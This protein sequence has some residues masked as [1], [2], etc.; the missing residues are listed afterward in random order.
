MEHDS[1]FEKQ[2][3][4]KNTTYEENQYGV[5]HMTTRRCRSATMPRIC[6]GSGAGSAIGLQSRAQPSSHHIVT[7]SFRYCEAL[8]A[9]HSC[10]LDESAKCF[11]LELESSRI[12]TIQSGFYSQIGNLLTGSLAL[13][14]GIA[15]QAQLM[16]SKRISGPSKN[17]SILK[18]RRFY[19]LLK[20]FFQ[21]PNI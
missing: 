19:V 6:A 3:A 13:R 14:V 1:K 8:T 20:T 9:R 4:S 18:H 17:V 21:Y 12:M 11:K 15:Q 10:I 2:I 7:D 5:F 16:I